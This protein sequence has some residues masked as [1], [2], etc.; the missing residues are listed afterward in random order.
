MVSNGMGMPGANGTTDSTEVC[1][2]EASTGSTGSCVGIISNGIGGISGLTCPEEDDEQEL[3]VRGTVS[4]CCDGALWSGVEEVCD[5][6]R[7]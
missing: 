3:E 2:D 6:A 7:S 4:C 1:D 5:W